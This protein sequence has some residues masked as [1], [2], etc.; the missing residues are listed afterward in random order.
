MKRVIISLFIIVSALSLS[1]QVNSTV[2]W[3][4]I[5]EAE[6][7][8]KKSPRPIFVDTYT[9]WCGW[10]KRLD[11]DVFTNPVIVQIL[12]EKYYPVKFNAESTE[13]VTFQGKTYKNDGA[14]GRAHQLAY[15]LLKG[16][17]SYPTVVFL[18][19]KAQVITPVP[20]F[21]SAKEFEPILIYFSGNDWQTK[22]YED[23]YS[24]FKGKIE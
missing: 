16:K 23:F 17:L 12:N 9:D 22:N 15:A 2:R 8:T 7:M 10:C 5:E 24:S 6:K 1:A 21:R 14:Y 13:P 20:G 11:S 18:N 3:Y 4:T 19:N